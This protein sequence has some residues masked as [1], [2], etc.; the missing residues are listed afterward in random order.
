MTDDT[1]RS[2]KN[3]ATREDTEALLKQL[4]Q[5]LE[6]EE[7]TEPRTYEETLHLAETLKERFQLLME[8]E[9]FVRGMLIEWKPGL[10][11]KKRPDYGEPIIV[12]EVLPEPVHDP[13]KAA[14][15]TYFREPLDFIGGFL[16]EMDSEES[17]F[18]LLHFDS[19]RFQRFNREQ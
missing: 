11:N 14:G 15:S 13:T 5:R 12:T 9:E 3:L 1:A 4:L 16:Q 18:V 19:R 2:S 10:K 7:L 6:Q 17:D 8:E